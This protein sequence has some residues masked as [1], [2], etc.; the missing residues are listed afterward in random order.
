MVELT[1]PL[2]SVRIYKVLDV[3]IVIARTS[4]PLNRLGGMFASTTVTPCATAMGITEATAHTIHLWV[5]CP[6]AWAKGR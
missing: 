4:H 1:H 5:K 3:S 6:P 2:D